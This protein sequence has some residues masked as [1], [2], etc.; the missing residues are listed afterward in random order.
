MA[1]KW[2]SQGREAGTRST[3][4]SALNCTACFVGSVRM[5]SPELYGMLHLQPLS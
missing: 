2:L 4:G 1:G 5:P 3:L